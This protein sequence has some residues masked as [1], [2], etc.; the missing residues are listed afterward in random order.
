MEGVVKFNEM[1]LD[2]LIYMVVIDEKFNEKG[3]IVLGLGDVG[4]CMYGIK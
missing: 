2:V 4:D 3:Y 1:Y